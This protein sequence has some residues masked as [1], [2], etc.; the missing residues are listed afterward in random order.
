[1]HLQ[2]AATLAEAL[3]LR[4]H[5][6]V[7]FT[8]GGGK[9]SAVFGL[10]SERAAERVLVT[11]TTRI[12]LPARD[13]A[14]LVLGGDL[15]EAMRRLE[16]GW[17]SGVR[18]LGTAAT[19]DMKLQGIPP[20]WVASLARVADRVLVEAD[21]AAGKPLTVPRDYEPVI[22]ASTE[23]LVPVCGFD[24]FGAPLDSQ[25]VHRAP[26]MIERLGHPEGHLLTAEDIAAVLLS[27][28]GSIKGAPPEAEIVPLVN[29]VDMLG[30]RTPRMGRRQ[31]WRAKRHHDLVRATELA[32][33]LL[34]Q[35]VPRVVLATLAAQPPG[36]M[37]VQPASAASPVSPHVEGG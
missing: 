14:E 16:A 1:V 33:V 20:E 25:H 26:E 18:A 19:F 24:V 11:T 30:P 35:G 28:W 21:G 29:K 5:R 37:V 17:S 6:V 12:W 27:P 31:E 2:N 9:T 10:A 13:Q 8:G 34:S 36:I 23:L 3:D 32:D 22:P 7:A 15:A 4:D